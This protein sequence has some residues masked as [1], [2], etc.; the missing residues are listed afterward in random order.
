MFQVGW[1]TLV[2]AFRNITGSI[3]CV[4]RLDRVEK[5]VG[6]YYF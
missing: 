4:D 1:G 5:R 3:L 6:Y 2:L